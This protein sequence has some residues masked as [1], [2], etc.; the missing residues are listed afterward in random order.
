MLIVGIY[1]DSDS[2]ADT[3]R[4]SGMNHANHIYLDQILRI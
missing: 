1:A 3:M 2:E 4:P